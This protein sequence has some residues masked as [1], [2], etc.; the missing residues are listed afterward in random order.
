MSNEKINEEQVEQT[1]SPA[2]ESINEAKAT[3]KKYVFFH[4]DDLKEDELR[5]FC[6]ALRDE[7][8]VVSESNVNLIAERDAL[9][10]QNEKL[11]TQLKN[12]QET[13]RIYAKYWHEEEEN[14]KTLKKLIH[15]IPVSD[16]LTAKELLRSILE[17]I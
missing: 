7:Y 1:T 14:V 11:Q 8:A 9:T 12:E 10:R 16:Y 4:S 6:E 3:I 13:S 2:T 5:E 17:K 15:S